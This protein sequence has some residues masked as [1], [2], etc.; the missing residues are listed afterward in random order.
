MKRK[1]FIIIFV[2]VL[3]VLIIAYILSPYLFGIKCAE[4]DSGSKV[5][6][7][8]DS[9][10]YDN[11]G[12]MYYFTPEYYVSDKAEK[13]YITLYNGN[14]YMAKDNQLEAEQLYITVCTKE[15]EDNSIKT[16]YYTSKYV[17]FD[18]EKTDMK[19]EKE[20]KQGNGFITIDE[21]K[22][23]AKIYLLNSRYGILKT[24]NLKK[25]S[26]FGSEIWD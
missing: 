14:V 16:Y 26:I 19:P 7:L 4:Y 24:V 20:W 3:L 15:E 21:K 22:E 12:N 13:I 25:Q 9:Y 23:T 18:R 2:E 10:P 6:G 11:E 5:I 17:V 8:T 1:K